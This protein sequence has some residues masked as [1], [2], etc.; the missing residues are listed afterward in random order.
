LAGSLV[1]LAGRYGVA[2][3]YDDWTGGRRTVAESTLVAVLAALSV[4]AATEAERAAALIDH[5]REHWRRTLAPTIVTRT[6]RSTSFWVHVTDGE[7]VDGLIQLEDGTV[8]TDLR[9]LQND[10]PPYE[11]DGR[12]IGEATF[13]LPAD[14]PAGYHRLHVDAGGVGADATLI[15]S[16]DT[17]ALPASLGSGRTWGLAVQLYSVRSERSWGIGDVT[18]LT[19]LAVWS[20]AQHDAGFIL[21]NPLHAAAPAAPMEPSPYLPTS[22]RFVNPMY[23]R[24]EAIPE[25]A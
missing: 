13:E 7:P 3:T 12:W 11:L 9:Q 4:P 18:D 22:R 17:V 2:A 16:P 5:D 8:R 14:L 15:V 25:F 6:G 24:V 20:A 23:L 1:E 19:D 10:R 21:V